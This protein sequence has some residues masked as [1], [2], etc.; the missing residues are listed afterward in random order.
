M[1][2]RSPVPPSQLAMARNADGRLE[3]FYVGTNHV[4]YHNF[5]T[6]PNGGWHGDLP[7]GGWAA[8]SHVRQIAVGQNLDGRLEVFYVAYNNT[9][10]HN[11]QT[12]P[13]GG[14]HGELAL[15]GSAKQIAVGQN[16]DGRLEIFY[17]GT[18]DAI[19]HNRQV[20]P[21]DAWGGEASFGGW[22]KQIA[23]AR[24]Q[25]GRLE[26]FY[27]GTDDAIYHSWQSDPNGEFARPLGARRRRQA[28]RDGSKSGW[29]IGG[30]LH[31][32][33]RQSASQPTG[34]GEWRVGRTRFIR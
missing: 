3:I 6:T 4:L 7:L 14:W 18:N 30:F 9:I 20:A 8:D 12:A 31:R 13:N 21:N 28:A 17:V 10:F 19:Y 25:D 24:N 34:C 29:P 11:F 33:G 22:A 2:P 32:Y 16:L 26:V 23:V 27:I 1:C 15:G 5:Q